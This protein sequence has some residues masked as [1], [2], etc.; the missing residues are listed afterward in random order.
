ME[1]GGYTSVSRDELNYFDQFQDSLQLTESCHAVLVF[2]RLSYNFGSRL[3]DCWD[4][5]L[6]LRLVNQANI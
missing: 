1:Y 6:G 4:G 3:R 2:F 5:V